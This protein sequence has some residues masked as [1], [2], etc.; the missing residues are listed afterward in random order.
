MS[1]AYLFHLVR[2]VGLTRPITPTE[3]RSILARAEFGATIRHLANEYGVPD[4]AIKTAL[5]DAAHNESDR[6]EKAAFAA[7]RR[8]L[9]TPP[10]ATAQRRDV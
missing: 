9:L 10:P 6:R 7:G 3:A 8:S 4:D 5:L 1:S 2:A